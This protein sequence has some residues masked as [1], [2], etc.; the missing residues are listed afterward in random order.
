MNEIVQS[1]QKP[2][3]LAYC[4]R[5]A[6]TIAQILPWAD[7]DDLSVGR[8]KS[9]LHPTQGYLLTTQKTIEVEHY[10]KKYLIT[11]MEVL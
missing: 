4:D 6:H 1:S 8:V 9:D 11:V 3:V 2:A 7:I 10:G 5:I